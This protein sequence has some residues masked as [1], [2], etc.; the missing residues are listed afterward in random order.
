MVDKINAVDKHIGARLR[1]R[2]IMLDLS[3]SQIAEALGVTFQQVQKYEKG[4]CRISATRL[5][6]L[7]QLLR[8]P[9]GFF[10]EGA[11]QAL[12]LPGPAEP[13]TEIPG[14]VSDFLATSAGM[15]LAEAFLRIPDARLRGAIVALVRQIASPSGEPE[16][17]GGAFARH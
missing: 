17:A 4:E 8:V 6:R 15:A 13:D 5:Q 11:P 16:Y 10:F 9:V 12:G 14:Y 1:M 2:R 7:C 3:L